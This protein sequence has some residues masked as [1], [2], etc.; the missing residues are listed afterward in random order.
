[1]S[2]FSFESGDLRERM[3]GKALIL[4]ERQKLIGADTLEASGKGV[5][6]PYYIIL[7]TV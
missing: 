4:E 6:K 7:Q 5:R 2:G 1:M 3:I